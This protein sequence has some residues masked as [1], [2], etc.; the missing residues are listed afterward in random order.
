MGVSGWLSSTGLGMGMKLARLPTRL[1]S[2]MTISSSSNQQVKLIRS[3]ESKKGREESGLVV[4][5]G[6][7]LINDALLA[8]IQPHQILVSQSGQRS[9]LYGWLQKALSQAKIGPSICSAV[10]DDVFGRCQ[11]QYMYMEPLQHSDV[12][13]MYSSLQFI[14]WKKPQKTVVVILDRTS[15]PRIAGTILGSSYGLGASA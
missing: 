12:Q 5:E 14:D 9:P 1:L 10:T 2:T 6:F 7:R 11:I 15:E 13:C 8:G 4:L 3:L